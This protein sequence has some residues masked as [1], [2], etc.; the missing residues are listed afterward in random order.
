MKKILFIILSL[1]THSSF[2][3]KVEHPNVIFIYA[4]DL[5]YGDL[6]CYGATKIQTPN[7]D[8]LAAS[9]VRFTDGHATSATCTP[10]RYALMT[11]RYPW[12]KDGTG[13]LPGDAALIIPTDKTTLPNL[14]K[15]AGYK[16]AIIGKWHLGLG[17]QV[18][19]NW[20]EDIKPGP[21]EVGF[22]YSFIFPA[23]ADRVPTVFMENHR[24]VAL[25][26]N[27]PITVDYVNKVGTDPTGKEHPELL[28]QQSS[29]NHGHN[30]TIVNGIGRIGY[31]S[32]GKMAR[33]VDEEITTTFL[34]KAQQFIETNHQSSFFLYFALTEPH[35]PRMPATMFRGKSGLGLRGDAILQL[36][37]TVGQIIKQLKDLKIDKNTI[38]VFSSDNGPVLNDGYEDEAVLKINGH[39]PAGQFRGGKYSILEG[40]TRVPFILSWP[41]TVK[42]Q[43]SEAMVSQMDLLASFSKLIKQPIPNGDAPDSENLLEAFLGKSTKGR[44]VFVEHA[45]TL[46]IIKDGWKY[47][48][49]SDGIAYNKLVGIETGNSKQPQLYNLKED[50][51]EKNNLAA[52]HPNLV[53]EL[54]KLLTTIKQKE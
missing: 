26:A 49:P 12:R 21:N 25:D 54:E 38:I 8:K 37:Y 4:D 39:I 3:Q 46:A 2:A 17:E 40:G 28:K 27:D 9:G 35:V 45:S 33:W 42:P 44:S 20:N 13:I 22:D 16:T 34:A 52:K 6:S 18:E 1:L 43:V 36:D 11:G 51:S 14:F 15:K 53:N 48:S 47:I 29:P 23:T 31:M 7:L 5:G 30:Q 50:K 32:G 19:K 41:G 10:S 24:V